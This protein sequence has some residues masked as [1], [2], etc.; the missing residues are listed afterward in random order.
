MIS[1][2]RLSKKAFRTT[3]ISIKMPSVTVL[4]H[5]FIQRIAKELMLWADGFIICGKCKN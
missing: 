3:L 1:P 4:Q 5:L 2:M